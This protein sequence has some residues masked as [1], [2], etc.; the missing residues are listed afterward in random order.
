MAAFAAQVPIALAQKC[1]MIY[2]PSPRFLSIAAVDNDPHLRRHAFIPPQARLYLL[3]ETVGEFW[4]NEHA[5]SYM[6][7]WAAIWLMQT[8]FKRMRRSRERGGTWH[9]KS[10]FFQ[11]TR[12]WASLPN[13]PV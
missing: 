1:D 8:N 12:Y 11:S 5:M 7:G 6:A 4:G 9:N 10:K 13:Y 3:E 2:Y